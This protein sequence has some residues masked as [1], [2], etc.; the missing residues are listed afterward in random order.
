VSLAQKFACVTKTTKNVEEIIGYSQQF[1]LG[2]NI[3]IIIP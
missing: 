3:K 2:K 1:L